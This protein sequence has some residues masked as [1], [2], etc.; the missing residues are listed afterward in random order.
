MLKIVDV[1]SS[2]DFNHANCVVSA[3][4]RLG[5]GHVVKLSGMSKGD[6]VVPRPVQ[7]ENGNTTYA[8]DLENG[9]IPRLQIAQTV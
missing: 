9:F 2:R 7:K 5:D 8:V 4:G 6:L 1:V 3:L